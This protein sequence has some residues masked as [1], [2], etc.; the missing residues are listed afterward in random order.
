MPSALHCPMK[1]LLRHRKTER[2]NEHVKEQQQ[3]DYRQ[4][5]PLIMA[6]GQQDATAD[7]EQGTHWPS[8]DKH[9]T[10]PV[11]YLRAPS[12]VTPYRQKLRQ[13]S[14]YQ[15]QEEYRNKGRYRIAPFKQPEGLGNTKGQEQQETTK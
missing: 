6:Q 7:K 5:K 3:P 14:A 1:D 11:T 10:R 13:R 8:L 12:G 9:L 4:P 15:R 2:T